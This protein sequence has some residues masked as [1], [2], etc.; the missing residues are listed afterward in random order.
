MILGSGPQHRREKN[1]KSAIPDGIME[2][3]GLPVSY[4]TIVLVL[5]A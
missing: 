5:N 3:K 2:E 1:Q 4:N